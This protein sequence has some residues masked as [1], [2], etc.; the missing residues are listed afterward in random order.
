MLSA[1]ERVPDPP[2]RPSAALI[3]YMRTILCREVYSYYYHDVEVRMHHHIIPSRSRAHIMHPQIYLLDLDPASPPPIIYILISRQQSRWE[4]SRPCMPSIRGMP[5]PQEGVLS[6]ESITL[7]CMDAN[8][9][10]RHWP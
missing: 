4:P 3:P 7:L 5:A 6:T 9:V 10:S 1:K 8:S 2:S